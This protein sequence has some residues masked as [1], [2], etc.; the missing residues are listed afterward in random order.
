MSD[1]SI[2]V[3][4]IA[5]APDA[6]KMAKAPGTA[7]SGPLLLGVTEMDVRIARQCLHAYWVPS[8]PSPGVNRG[9]VPVPG[10]CTRSASSTRPRLGL[11]GI[12]SKR[13]TSLY[14]GGPSKNWLKIKNMVEGEFVLLGTEV[15]DSGIPWAL[16]AREQ[17]GQLEFAGPAILRLPSNARAEWADQ[18]APMSIDKPALKG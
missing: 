4:T 16:L 12:V 18:F 10:C 6:L 5:P 7:F 8:T 14:R 1:R 3:G 9:K 11:E 15:D 17:D 2:S 13:V